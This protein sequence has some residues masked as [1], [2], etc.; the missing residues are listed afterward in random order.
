[1]EAKIPHTINRFCTH[2]T[3]MRIINTVELNRIL[4]PASSGVGEPQRTAKTIFTKCNDAGHFL[5]LTMP[6]NPKTN[7]MQ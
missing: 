1:M 3:H 7:L 5:T 6:I 2:Y 4:I